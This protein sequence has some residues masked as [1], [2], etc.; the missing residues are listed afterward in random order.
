MRRGGNPICNTPSYE[1]VQI[2]RG[3][4]VAVK[5]HSVPAENDERRSRVVQLDEEVPKVLGNVDHVRRPGTARHGISRR[6]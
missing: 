5:C 2:L 6:V 1:H 3:A 4:R